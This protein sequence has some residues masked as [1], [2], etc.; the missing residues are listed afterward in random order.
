LLPFFGTSIVLIFL[1]RLVPHE[2]FFD[3]LSFGKINR[4]SR[5]L[6]ILTSILSTAA[7]IAWAFWTNHL[8]LGE[9]FVRGFGDAS[10]LLIFGVYIP[11]FALLNAFAEEMV[12]R[13]FI[14]ESLSRV[15]SNPL[16]ILV[17]QASAFAAAHFR[18]GFPNGWTG[19]GMVFIYGSM[20]G[21]LRMRTRGML[22]PYIAH[23]IADYAIALL[24][25]YLVK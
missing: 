20:L 16:V 24:L 8:G 10:K 13:G 6:I 2:K 15:F 1:S 19:Y 9:Q 22:A 4:F 12:Y 17:F 11:A 21:F 7:L 3:W 14:Q 23:V 25:V 5:F 18:G